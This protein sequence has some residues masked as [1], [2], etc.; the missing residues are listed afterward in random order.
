MN[1][2]EILNN[3]DASFLLAKERNNKKVVIAVPHHAPIG[4]SKL[5]CAQHEISDENAGVLGDYISRL[6]NCCSIVA[7]NYFIDSNKSKESDYFKRIQTW[8]PKFLI[9]IHGHGSRL[10]NY[11][12]EISSGSLENNTWSKK[13]AE[14]LQRKM[15]DARALRDFTISG[16]YNQ[17]YFKASSSITISTDNWISFHIELPKAIRAKKSVSIQFCELLADCIEELL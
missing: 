1:T 17:I 2:K 3:S 10:A 13:L 14:K 4:T 12:I 11:D 6:L 7:C 15:A 8:K 16:N 5:P 9:E